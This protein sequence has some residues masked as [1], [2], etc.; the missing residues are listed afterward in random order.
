[1][2]A[3]AYKPGRWGGSGG[4]PHVRGASIGGL[5]VSAAVTGWLP[6][7]SWPAA[8]GRGRTHLVLGL[9]IIKT[10]DDVGQHVIGQGLDARAVRTE[11]TGAFV[12]GMPG[13]SGL[14]LGHVRRQ[15]LEIARDADLLVDSRSGPDGRMHVTV[16]RPDVP[17]AFFAQSNAL[18]GPDKETSP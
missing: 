11:A 6:G 13:M 14:L 12:S 7:C 17:T 10:T 2:S 5:L 3:R 1:M 9:G 4:G 18:P 15:E 8:D 16:G